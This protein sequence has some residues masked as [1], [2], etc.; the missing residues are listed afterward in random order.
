MGKCVQYLFLTKLGR[1]SLVDKV[2]R[3]TKDSSTS[4]ILHIFF[5]PKA[6]KHKLFKYNT[7]E[8]EKISYKLIKMLELL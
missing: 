1:G 7:L 8:G 5:F 2:K 4:K 6:N 3:I